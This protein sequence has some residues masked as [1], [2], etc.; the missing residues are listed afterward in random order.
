MTAAGPGME[1][2][3]IGADM[4]SCS[5]GRDTG[6]ASGRPHRNHES[7]FAIPSAPTRRHSIK[8]INQPPGS[9]I[10][11][12]SSSIGDGASAGGRGLRARCGSIRATSTS[13]IRFLLP[14]KTPPGTVIV[15]GE[16]PPKL[17][18]LI[19]RP[20]RR[21][22]TAWDIWVA[23]LIVYSI[24]FVPLRVG[25]AWRSC[26]FQSDW[27]WDV[28]VDLCFATDIVLCFRTAVVI[29]YG[30]R[31]QQLLISSPRV[32]AHRYF[33]TCTRMPVDPSAFTLSPFATF[34]LPAAN[35]LSR[36][37][38]LNTSRFL[39][40]SRVP[41]RSSLHGSRRHVCRLALVCRIRLH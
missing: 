25:F 18:P 13:V 20:G 2:D 29:E 9:D 12:S 26:I 38:P 6:E 21:W 14:S 5:R 30:E 32:I 39:D 34:S 1:A 22:K 7:S 40:L 19:I 27:W 28:L 31:N 11:S 3:A 15:S 41:D 23:V 37:R 8:P 36:C 24:L 4:A 33:C 35:F 16:E 17:P 10:M